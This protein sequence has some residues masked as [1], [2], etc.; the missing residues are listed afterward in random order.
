MCLDVYTNTVTLKYKLATRWL[1]CS[2][3][4]SRIDASKLI[5]SST[6]I[7]LVHVLSYLPQPIFN[8]PLQE[9]MQSHT[10]KCDWFTHDEAPVG[11]GPKPKRPSTAQ[12]RTSNCNWFTHDATNQSGVDI[13]RCL[14]RVRGEGKEYAMRNRVRFFVL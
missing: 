5:S 3:F 9:I 13:R 12:A 1:F 10:Q 14:R 11:A 4:Q 8:F 2:V 7:R 6:L